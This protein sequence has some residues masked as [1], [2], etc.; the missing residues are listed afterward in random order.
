[1]TELLQRYIKGE[2]SEEEKRRVML[3]L[4]ENPENMREYRTLRKLYDISLWNTGMPSA[5]RQARI[6]LLSS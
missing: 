5:S 6:V 3:W 1:M 4:E 2:A